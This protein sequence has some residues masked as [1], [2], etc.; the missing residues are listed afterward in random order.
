MTCLRTGEHLSFMEVLETGPDMHEW[1]RKSA[2]V[3]NIVRLTK[4]VS[5]SSAVLFGKLQ[6]VQNSPNNV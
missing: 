4:V 6:Y 3:E 2:E 5:L 1:S